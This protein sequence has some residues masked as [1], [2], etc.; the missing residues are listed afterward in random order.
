MPKRKR[1]FTDKIFHAINGPPLSKN[2][3]LKNKKSKALD[4]KIISGL[5]KFLESPF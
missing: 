5:K 4:A 1:I 2:V 3:K